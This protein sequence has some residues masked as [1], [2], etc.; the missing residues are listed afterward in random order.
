MDTRPDGQINVQADEEMDVRTGGRTDEQMDGW[1][2]RGAEGTSLTEISASLLASQ[3]RSDI[4]A[5]LHPALS[6]LQAQLTDLAA[7]LPDDLVPQINAALTQFYKFALE[8]S[9][10]LERLE[11]EL[12]LE[13]QPM[14]TDLDLQSLQIDQDAPTESYVH[15][16]LEFVRASV[17]EGK[18][19]KE[20]LRQWL[21]R[22]RRENPGQSYAALAEI[23]NIAGIPTL[24]GR[25][26]WNRGT[27]RNLLTDR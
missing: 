19:D 3:I 18:P 12:G 23:L 15:A 6:N 25:D 1:R 20:S 26:T 21:Q 9:A 16:D 5:H 8:I 13:P 4:L 11:Q 2:D 17:F 27:L 22:Q 24:S 14:E 10:R 7:S